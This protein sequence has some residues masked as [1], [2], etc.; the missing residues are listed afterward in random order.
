MK[1]LN[2]INT[3]ARELSSTELEQ[4]NGGLFGIGR[5]IGNKIADC[6]YGPLGQ[7]E[8]GN[9]KAGHSVMVSRVLK[10]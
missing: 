9:T 4:V 8:G 3:E 2:N 5:Y 6:I 10:K 1:S 7:R